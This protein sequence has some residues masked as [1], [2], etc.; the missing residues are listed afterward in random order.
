MQLVLS[1]EGWQ[2]LITVNDAL[3]FLRFATTG[4]TQQSTRICFR[5]G[6]AK[7]FFIEKILQLIVGR[8]KDVGQFLL[9]P[10]NDFQQIECFVNHYHLTTKQRDG[11]RY[12]TVYVCV[13]PFVHVSLFSSVLF[14]AV[15]ANMEQGCISQ[16]RWHKDTYCVLEFVIPYNMSRIML[17]G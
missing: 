1:R 6:C 11:Y 9:L 14:P 7:Y 4:N 8:L 2:F 3:L 10:R 15:N 13:H 12:C 16:T 17:C 5:R